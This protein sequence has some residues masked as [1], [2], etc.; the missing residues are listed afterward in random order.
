MARFIN[1]L[2]FSCTAALAAAGPLAAQELWELGVAGGYGFSKDAT[3]ENAAGKASAGLRPGPL[4]GIVAGNHVR[5]WLSGEARYM[6]R[7]NDL[8]LSSGGTEARLDAESHTLHYDFLF[9]AGKRG[10]VQPFVAAGAGIRFFRGTGQNFR[11]QP[12]NR[13][14]T[15][16]HT[17]EICPLISLG[18]GLRIPVSSLLSV[19]VEVRDYMT[20]LP[21]EVIAPARGARTSGWLHD[22][23]PFIGLSFTF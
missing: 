3:I 16:T 2:L 14:A 22:F 17:S 21:E 10:R 8:R 9:S 13:F 7:Q 12:L 15:L 23:A 1:I 4:F 20:P 6:Y 5:S 11:A 18:G 19:R